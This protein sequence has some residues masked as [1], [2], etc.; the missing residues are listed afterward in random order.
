MSYQMTYRF[1]KFLKSLKNNVILE[2]SLFCPCKNVIL[3]GIQ[4]LY[5]IE[6]PCVSANRI[7]DQFSFASFSLRFAEPKRKL[8]GMT[9]P[10]TLQNFEER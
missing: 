7:P 8:S 6:S 5:R 3:S 2:K 9:F 4:F 1:L 10:G